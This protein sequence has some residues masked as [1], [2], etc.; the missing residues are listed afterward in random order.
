M[1]SENLCVVKKLMD[2]FSCQDR[3]AALMCLDSNEALEAVGL[4]E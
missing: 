2:A 4:A 3:E 1:S